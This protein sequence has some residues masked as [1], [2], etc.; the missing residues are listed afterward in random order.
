MS[1]KYLLLLALILPGITLAETL[2][3]R[4]VG[5]NADYPHPVAPVRRYAEGALKTNEAL[6]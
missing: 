6:L 1:W 5:I 4:V 3:G 2:A